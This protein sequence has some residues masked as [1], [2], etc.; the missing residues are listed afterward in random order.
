MVQFFGRK[1]R[2]KILPHIIQS[3][4]ATCIIQSWHLNSSSSFLS[5]TRH[6]AAIHIF[7]DSVTY[8]FTLRSLRILFFAPFNKSTESPWLIG[9][10]P[11]NQLTFINTCNTIK[12]FSQQTNI[13]NVFLIR[14]IVI[15]LI[16]QT[17]KITQKERLSSISQ[18]LNNQ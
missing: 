8:Y 3:K 18:R 17:R 5:Y 16:S 1:M 9:F 15:I 10:E 11:H 12:D 2:I 14:I 4:L 7:S 6:I 13:N